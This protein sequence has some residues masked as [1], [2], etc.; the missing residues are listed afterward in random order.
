MWLSSYCLFTLRQDW[1]FLGNMTEKA[2]SKLLVSVKHFC[3]PYSIKSN[4]FKNEF[5]DYIC[6]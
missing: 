4:V 3:R 5:A 2:D 6:E 1:R